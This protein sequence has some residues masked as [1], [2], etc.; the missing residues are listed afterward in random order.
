MFLETK[1]DKE[2]GKVCL[3]FSA[4]PLHD[5]INFQATG[6][7]YAME[8]TELTGILFWYQGILFR[9]QVKLPKCFVC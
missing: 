4:F 7:H 8:V 9:Y 3:I 2:S 6:H 1:W 5:Y